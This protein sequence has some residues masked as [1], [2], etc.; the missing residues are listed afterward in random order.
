MNYLLEIVIFNVVVFTIC[1]IN[2]VKK[3]RLGIIQ[4]YPKAIQDRCRQLGLIQE[5]ST[6]LTKKAT[7]GKLGFFIAYILLQTALAYYI[8]GARTFFEGWLHAY[9][10][11]VVEMWFDALVIDCLWFCHSKKMII[12]GTEDMVDAYHDYWH[13]IKYAVIGMFTQAV[14]SVPVGFLIMLLSKCY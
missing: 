11:W 5:S 7:I 2:M 13:H 3:G 9:I 1:G 12:P 4:E 6:K 10:M 8:G 14:I